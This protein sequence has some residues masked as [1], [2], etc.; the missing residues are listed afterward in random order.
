MENLSVVIKETYTSIFANQ[1]FYVS[2]HVGPQFVHAF[3]SFNLS[4][5]GLNFH[6]S[7]GFC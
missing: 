3:F 2:A 4:V 7:D 1:Q 5:H 6:L